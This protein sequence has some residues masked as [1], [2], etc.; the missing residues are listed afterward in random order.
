MMKI[1]YDK[2][3][4][5]KSNVMNQPEDKKIQ[6]KEL[7]WNIIV[8]FLRVLNSEKNAVKRKSCSFFLK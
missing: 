6:G 4:D 1:G 3:L 8:V 7:F 5:T 2:R